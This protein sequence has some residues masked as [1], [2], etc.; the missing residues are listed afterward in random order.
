MLL[1]STCFLLPCSTLNLNSAEYFLLFVTASIMKKDDEWTSRSCSAPC[2]PADPEIWLT[3]L[4]TPLTCDRSTALTC[5]E[6]VISRVVHFLPQQLGACCG[7]PSVSGNL[8]EITT[9]HSSANAAPELCLERAVWA[10][11]RR[12][13]WGFL[14]WQLQPGVEEFSETEARL[15]QLWGTKRQN[16]LPLFSVEFKLKILEEKWCVL[17]A[18]SLVSFIWEFASLKNHYVI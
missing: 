8:A 6:R 4:K 17:V 14:F 13:G 15:L 1:S 7:G 11:P 5:C 16:P 10:S 2:L 3:V 12:V 18:R 9:A